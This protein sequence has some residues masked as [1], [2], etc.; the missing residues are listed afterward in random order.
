MQ[1]DRGQAAPYCTVRKL[2]RSPSQ[3]CEPR[4]LDHRKH[5]RSMQGPCIR[6]SQAAPA[7][8]RESAYVLGSGL[9]LGAGYKQTDKHHAK[10]PTSNPFMC[11][12]TASL[13]NSM[14]V[15]W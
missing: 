6:S 4:T 3:K 5:T 9:G 2:Q 10:T 7:A 11:E 1:P 15:M 8:L 13:R 12:H 14:S